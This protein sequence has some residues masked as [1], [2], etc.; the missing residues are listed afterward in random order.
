ML[1]KYQS[2]SLNGW[3]LQ[4]C[5]GVLRVYYFA[6]ARYKSKNHFQIFVYAER[7]IILTILCI[8]CN[9]FVEIKSS[10]KVQKFSLRMVNGIM[11]WP[12]LVITKSR[13]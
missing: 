7:F 9:N 12:L 6:D 10:G 4:M 13:V 8:Y 3:S 5:G 2:M 1:N 11:Q